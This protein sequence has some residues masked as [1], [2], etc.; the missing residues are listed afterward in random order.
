MG[1]SGGD[2]TIALPLTPRHWPARGVTPLRA[3][4]G[5]QTAWQQVGGARGGCAMWQPTEERRGGPAE[6]GIGLSGRVVVSR[7]KGCG[8]DARSFDERG[9][10]FF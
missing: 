5:R 7:A 3:R 9:F 6:K 4:C 10:T 2:L 8:V 1:A